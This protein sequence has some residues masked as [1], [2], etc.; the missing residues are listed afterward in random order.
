MD[1]KITKSRVQTKLQDLRKKAK[2]PGFRQGH[3]P[4]GMIKKMA[5]ASTMVEEINQILSKSINEYISENKLNILGNPIPKNE[6]DSDIDWN[7]QK[8]FEFEFELG[9]A[10]NIDFEY[11]D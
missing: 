10:P 6:D 8:D 3:V 11:F 1:L 7:E 9:F 4:I 5:G 2:I